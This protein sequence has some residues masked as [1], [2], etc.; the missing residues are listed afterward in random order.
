MR[1]VGSADRCS[2]RG[3]LEFHH[4]VPHAVGGTADAENIQLRCRA[5]NAFE[6]DLFF[7]CDAIRERGP[8]YRVG[9]GPGPS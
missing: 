6:A 8:A 9:L 7:T 3:F 5:H 1:F 2:E 4:V